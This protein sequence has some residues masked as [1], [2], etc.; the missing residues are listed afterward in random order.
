MAHPL[1]E[2]KSG[3]VRG[4]TNA[5]LDAVDEGLVSPADLINDFLCYLSESDVKDFVQ[6]NY[7][8]RDDDNECMIRV[9]GEN[10]LEEA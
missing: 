4:Y 2:V 8:F 5:L 3:A 1:I 7:R 6:K 10:E 9:P